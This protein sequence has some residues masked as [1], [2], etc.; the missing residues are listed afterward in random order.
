MILT[1]S[2]LISQVIMGFVAAQIIGEAGASSLGFSAF[3]TANTVGL[4]SISVLILRSIDAVSARTVTW[5]ALLI[6][7]SP[8]IGPNVALFVVET[9]STVFRSLSLGFRFA[10]NNTAGHLL[11]HILIGAGLCV[12]GVLNFYLILCFSAFEALVLFIQVS[13]ISILSTT[14]LTI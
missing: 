3:L 10:A 6:G 14:Y 11:M 5:G 4:I 9:L 1:A 12:P 2:S 7:A 13:V 8:A